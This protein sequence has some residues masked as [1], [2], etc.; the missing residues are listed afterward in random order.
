MKINWFAVVIISF[1]FCPFL[2]TI[3]IKNSDPVGA[4]LTTSIIFSF[5]YM[6]HKL[7]IK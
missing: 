4:A 3:F 7:N 5:G 6:I 2:D 1:W